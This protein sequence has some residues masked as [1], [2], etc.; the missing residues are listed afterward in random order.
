[1]IVGSACEQGELFKA[2]VAG[3]PWGELCDIAKFYDFLEIQPI[4]NNEFMV[5]E[6]TAKDDNQ[7]QDF[8]RT[9]VRLGEKL[10]I[11]VCATCDV[12]FMDPEDEVYRRILMAGQ[13][14]TD[15]DIQA[16][17][18]L[19]TTNEML[20]EFEYLGKEK[21]HEKLNMHNVKQKD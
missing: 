15:A 11:P 7:L 18:Y 9:V 17:L 4:G 3:R 12:H 13:G 10:N 21:A 16:P 14:F 5:R 2:I 1:L 6:G 8:N 19:R 20:R